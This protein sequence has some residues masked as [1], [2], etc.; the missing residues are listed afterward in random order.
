M[1]DPDATAAGALDAALADPARLDAAPLIALPPTAALDDTLRAFADAHGAAALPVLE[2]LARDRVGPRAAARR[3]AGRSTASPSAGCSRRPPAGAG[4]SSSG[5]RERAARAWLS[6]DRRQRLAR[7]VDPVR[8]RAS[9]AW[10]SARSSSTTRSASSTPPAARSRK[11]RLE[12]E[13]AALRASQKLPWVEVEPARALAVVGEALT[14]ASRARHRAA[15]RLRAL[16][17][18]LRAERSRR[19][20]RR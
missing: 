2:A 13:L 15:G 4:R 8:R 17:A 11:K 16:G 7:G 18:A 10:R 19:R 14:A 5:V 6:G 12:T 20:Y 1:T 3:A 9:A